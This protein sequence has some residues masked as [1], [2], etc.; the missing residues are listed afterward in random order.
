MR[1]IR[2]VAT[3][4][5]FSSILRPLDLLY[6]ELSAFTHSRPDSSDVQLWQS[7]GPI[8]AQEGFRLVYDLQTSAYVGCYALTKVGRAKFDL[9]KGVEFLFETSGAYQRNEIAN[10]YR[11]LSS[12]NTDS[13]SR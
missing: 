2:R 13:S 1:K 10:G 6:R 9:P 5:D 11:N 3:T 4:V 8:Y 7:N 12:A